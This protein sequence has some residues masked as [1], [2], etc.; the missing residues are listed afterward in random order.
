MTDDNAALH[1]WLHGQLY[2]E[3]DFDRPRDDRYGGD[4]GRLTTSLG[5]A[6][7]VTSVVADSWLATD[8]GPVM[9]RPVLDIDLPVHVT[10]SSTPGHHHLFI[11]KQMTWATYSTLLLALVDAG[12]I[13]RGYAEASIDRGRTDVRLPWIKKGQRS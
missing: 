13:E 4:N 9:H 8:G 11:D 7:T 10:P 2:A 6:T 12:I 3:V 5:E 1:P